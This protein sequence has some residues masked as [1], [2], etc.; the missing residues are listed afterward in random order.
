MLSSLVRSQQGS[1]KAE[2]F[3]HR[4]MGFHQALVE[5]YNPPQT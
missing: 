1:E 3:Q 5:F 4:F 2:Q